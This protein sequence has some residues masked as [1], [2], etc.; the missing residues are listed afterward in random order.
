MKL[1]LYSFMVCATPLLLAYSK[2]NIEQNALEN[3]WTG[4][5]FEM[6]VIHNS[7]DVWVHLEQNNAF[8][9]AYNITILRYL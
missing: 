1:K 6:T 4:H 2:P 7:V 5:T 3:I 8:T 9:C